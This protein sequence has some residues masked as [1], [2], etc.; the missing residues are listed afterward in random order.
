MS[1]SNN[2]KFKSA[3]EEFCEAWDIDYALLLLPT[4]KGDVGL[5][6]VNLN[7][8]QIIRLIKIINDRSADL[9][10]KRLDS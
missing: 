3:L 10:K 9:P 2:P 8:E 6:G 5:M 4:Q 1:L 7:R